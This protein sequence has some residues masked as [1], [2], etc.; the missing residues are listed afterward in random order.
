L[1]FHPAEVATNW[2]GALL[3]AVRLAGTS[4]QPTSRAKRPAHSHSHSISALASSWRPSLQSASARAQ[5]CWP[6]TQPKLYTGSGGGHCSNPKLIYAGSRHRGGPQPHRS[7]ARKSKL[8]GPVQSAS[9]RA[10]RCWPSTQPKLYTGSRSPLLGSSLSGS[11]PKLIYA[12]SRHRGGPQ[13]H[14]SEARKSKLDGPER[15]PCCSRALGEAPSHSA[16]Q[17]GQSCVHIGQRST[18]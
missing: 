8:D 6:S 16:G 18:T 14:R 13:P 7:E 9:A 15:P 12:G 2:D 11:N 1:A 10:Q 5:R 4:A 3:D 17:T